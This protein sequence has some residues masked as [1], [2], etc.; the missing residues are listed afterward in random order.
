MKTSQDKQSGRNSTAKSLKSSRDW[1][2]EGSAFQRLSSQPGGAGGAWWDLEGSTE[3]GIYGCPERQVRKEKF[4]W[5]IF[6]SSI[7]TLWCSW[8]KN[9]GK[10]EFARIIFLPVPFL[11][12]LS[13]LFSSPWCGSFLF[14]WYRGVSYSISGLVIRLNLLCWFWSLLGGCCS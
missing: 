14:L 10:K 11:L 8:L 13:C 4:R 3:V 9:K 5:S 2:R 7:Q 1:R 12:L 6:L